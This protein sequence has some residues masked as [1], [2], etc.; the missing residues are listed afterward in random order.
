MQSMHFTYVAK[1]I[2]IHWI[3]SSYVHIVI[4]IISKHKRIIAI[5][6]YVCMYTASYACISK[7]HQSKGIKKVVLK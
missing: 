3:N 7:D 1:Y 5:C 6:M 4:A 2:A